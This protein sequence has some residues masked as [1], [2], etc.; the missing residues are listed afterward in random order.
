[1]RSS[2]RTV[3]GVDRPESRGNQKWGVKEKER[4]T[5]FAMVLRLHSMLKKPSLKWG[6]AFVGIPPR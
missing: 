1:L 3:T 4:G 5:K 6:A 2:W